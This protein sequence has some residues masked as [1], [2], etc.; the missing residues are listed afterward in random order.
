M[1]TKI[2]IMLAITA[3][4]FQN[5][6]F[7]NLLDKKF[8]IDEPARKTHAQEI[9]GKK[10]RKS[11]LSK[12]EGEK[13][14]H[15]YIYD[16]VN[17]RLPKKFKNKSKDITKAII[18]ESKKYEMDPLFIMSV[19]ATESSF[20]PEAKGTSGEIG[21]MQLMPETGKEVAQKVKEHWQGTVTLKDPIKNIRIGAAYLNQLRNYFDNNPNK[22]ISAYNSGIGKIRKIAKNEDLP[23]IYPTKIL[24]YYE[25]LYKKIVSNKVP[26]NLAIN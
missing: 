2:I 16:I 1:K 15:V 14:L 7:V 6:S 8:L 22:Y 4:F 26:D 19:I 24:K 3:F 25:A 13:F 21:L 20:N 12:I 23:K 10:Y 11:A 18:Q 5:F 17:Q 9:L